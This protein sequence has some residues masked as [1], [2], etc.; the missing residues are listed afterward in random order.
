MMLDAE[1]VPTL[2]IV[3]A[4]I[5]A[6][7]FLLAFLASR[8]NWPFKP[9]ATEAGHRPAYT[10]RVGAVLG[11]TFLSTPFVRVSTYDDFVVIAPIL[12]GTYV[13]RRSDGV[14][15]EREEQKVPWFP[16]TQVS[17]ILLHDVPR[18]PAMLRLL[19]RDA[20]ALEMALRASLGASEGC[21]PSTRRP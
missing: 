19:P 7:M 6:A 11:S 2:M 3:C 4:T 10:A 15:V 12:L 18:V 17:L 9:T 8:V 20:R 21:E 1:D 13:L 16:M 5:L 14:R